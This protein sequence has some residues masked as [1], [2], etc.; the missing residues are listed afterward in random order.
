MPPTVTIRKA[1][2]SDLDAVIALDIAVRSAPGQPEHSAE[3]LEP[4]P[5]GRL[6][7]WVT[8]GECYIAE[9]NGTM[10]G[11]GVFHHHFF[12]S[13]MIDLVIVHPAFR[14]QGVGRA[15]ISGMAQD[16]QSPRL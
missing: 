3:R 1:E 8:R 14:R 11:F 5:F 16:C 9:S 7:D 13:G 6:R 15:L 12:H 2:L 4:D 10:V